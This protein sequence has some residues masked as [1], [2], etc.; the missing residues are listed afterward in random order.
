M[1]EYIVTI[2]LAACLIGACSRDVSHHEEKESYPKE[3]Y[4]NANLGSIVIINDTVAVVYNRTGLNT[5]DAQIINLKD[6][7]QR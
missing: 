4:N 6:F 3:V 1:R 7:E 2:C 5:S